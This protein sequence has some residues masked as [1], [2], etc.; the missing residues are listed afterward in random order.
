MGGPLASFEASTGRI[1]AL[2]PHQASFFGSGGALFGIYLRNILLTL[3]TLG[4]YYL[5]GKNRL[6]TYVV[7]QCEFQGDRFAWHGTGKELFIGALKVF[8][9]LAPVFFL[10]SVAPVLWKNIASE[11]ASKAAGL[12]VYL[13][14]VPLAMVGTR[15]YR[16]SRLSWRGIR[17]SFRGRVRD[18][19]KLFLRGAIFTG[20]TFGLYTPFFQTQ[21]RKFFSENTYFGNARFAFDGKGSDLFGRL[22]LSLLVAAVA[23]GV[24]AVV[25]VAAMGQFRLSRLTGEEA[26]SQAVVAAL[27]GFAVAILVA[28]VAW[29][30]YLAY[31]H[32]YYW[33]HTSFQETHFRSTVTAGKLLGLWVSNLLLIVVTLGLAI[34]WVLAR[35]VRFNLANI[36]LIGSLDLSRI[37]QEAQKA[38]AGAE[39]LAGMLNIDFAGFD[40]PF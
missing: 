7:G 22:L 14:L 12:L 35:N 38:G 1:V 34:P 18:F 23:F 11:L 31:R 19:L 13:F 26:I 37:V 29:F 32:R 39:S 6:R 15:R 36:T 40:L 27:P 3:V 21:Q 28:V 4:I 30:W 16:F 8:G 17:F 20:L 10:I 33:S 24:A 5:W 9:V 25:A 2:T